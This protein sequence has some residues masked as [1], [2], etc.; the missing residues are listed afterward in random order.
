MKR[1]EILWEWK[2]A[3]VVAGI[4]TDTVLGDGQIGNSETRRTILECA[5]REVAA[6]IERAGAIDPEE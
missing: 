5:A 1:S 3:A 4:M 2:S 6:R